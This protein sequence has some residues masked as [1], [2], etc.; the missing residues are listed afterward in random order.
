MTYIEKTNLYWLWQ[1]FTFVYCYYY[2]Y[3]TCPWYDCP[4]SY[5]YA[6]P[7]KHKHQ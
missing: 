5:S 3:A 4:A 7:P 2:Y 6:A 1:V